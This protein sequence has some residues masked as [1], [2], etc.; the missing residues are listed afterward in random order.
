MVRIPIRAIV[1]NTGTVESLSA[2]ALPSN[3]D[4]LLGTFRKGAG[5]RFGLPGKA[6]SRWP[7]TWKQ[8][9]NSLVSL[10]NSLA[11]ETPSSSAMPVFAATTCRRAETVRVSPC[12]RLHRGV[13]E[14]EQ[15]LDR[16]QTMPMTIGWA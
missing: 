2:I 4:Y 12:I 14:W 13:I 9:P 5:W 1:W 11:L 15:D 3:L 16:P 7:S 10:R 8:Y 6:G